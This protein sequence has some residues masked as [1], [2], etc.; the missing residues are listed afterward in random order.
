M[1]K[2]RWGVLGTA[3]IARKQVI[4]AMQNSTIT[5]IQGIA[6]R[7]LRKAQGAAQE[8]DIPRAFGSYEE[9][10]AFEEID[11]VYIPLPNQSAYRMDS[12]E[13]AGG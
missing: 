13:L 3:D 9:L 1:K 2:I 4:P 12:Q 11:A 7:D 8:L 5:Q 10:L 6:S